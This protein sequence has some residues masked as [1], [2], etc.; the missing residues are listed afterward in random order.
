MV[1]GEQNLAERKHGNPGD[2]LLETDVKEHDTNGKC[3][4]VFM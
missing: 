2:T 3:C 4:A 1:V